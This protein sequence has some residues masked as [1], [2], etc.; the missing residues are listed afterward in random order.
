MTF[1]ARFISFSTLLTT[2]TPISYNEYTGIVT[3]NWLTTSG[4]VMIAESI[5]ITTMSV[6]VFF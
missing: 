1:S 6:V 3:N 4:G 5:S 2:K